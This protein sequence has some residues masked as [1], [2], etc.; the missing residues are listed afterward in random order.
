MLLCCSILIFEYQTSYSVVNR[1]NVRRKT[2]TKIVEWFFNDTKQSKLQQWLTIYYA[3]KKSLFSARCNFMVTYKIDHP[4][5]FLM[6]R[7]KPRILLL[8][9]INKSLQVTVQKYFL[10][11]TQVIA[12]FSLKK[13]FHLGLN[14]FTIISGQFSNYS[15]KRFHFYMTKF[16]TC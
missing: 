2:N 15:Y 7:E 1:M 16:S 4:Y 12:K 10:Q 13:H 3:L 14:F 6:H 11:D 8:R 5:T 9:M